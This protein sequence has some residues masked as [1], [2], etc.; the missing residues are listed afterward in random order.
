MPAASSTTST[1][2]PSPRSIVATIHPFSGGPETFAKGGMALSTLHA[3]PRK[4]LG[5]AIRRARAWGCGGVYIDVT[6]KVPRLVKG[7]GIRKQVMEFSFASLWSWG[8]RHDQSTPEALWARDLEHI[9]AEM[10]GWLATRLAYVGNP[11]KCPVLAALSPAEAI[12]AAEWTMRTI[13]DAGFNAIAIDASALD[14]ERTWACWLGL[15]ARYDMTLYVEGPPPATGKP[16]IDGVPC[17]QTTEQWRGVAEG[18][19]TGLKPPAAWPGES[20]IAYGACPDADLEHAPLDRQLHFLVRA[21]KSAGVRAGMGIMHWQD[22][23]A[24]LND[25]GLRENGA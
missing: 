24:M 8:T 13:M 6:P 22:R 9:S 3:G 18:V 21:A 17:I 15:A 25:L 19:V 14:D 5:P 23:D 4:S 11:G 2:T 16:W 7:G 10:T 20:I 12:I 1:A